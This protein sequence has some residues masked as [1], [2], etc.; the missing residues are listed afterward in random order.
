MQR[1]KP[2]KRSEAWKAVLSRA[3]KVELLLLD[4]DGVLTDGSLQY[5]DRGDECKRFSTRDGL[6]IRLLQES[7]VQV[8]VIT[9][10]TSQIVRRRAEELKM[11]HLY[12]G[13]FD[14]LS[15]YEEILQK[16]GLR[17]PQTAYIGDDWIDLPLLNRVGLAVAPA[18]GAVEIHSRVHYRTQN[19]GG[20]GAVREICD[21]IMEARGTYASMLAR[22]DT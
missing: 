1:N 10:R 22:F 4:V 9:A 12:Q 11:T 15:A 3:R 19:S 7:G 6:G 17:P 2:V 18:N 21:L 5:T 16:T 8:G 13:R 20:D 14:K